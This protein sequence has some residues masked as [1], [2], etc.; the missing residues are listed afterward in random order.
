M[1][2]WKS[3]G[4]ILCL[5]LLVKKFLAKALTQAFAKATVDIIPFF[6]KGI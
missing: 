4:L 1:R 5:A 6:F 2:L 3:T